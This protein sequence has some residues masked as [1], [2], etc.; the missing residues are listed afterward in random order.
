MLQQGYPGRMPRRC[1]RYAR[2][3]VK[4][5]VPRFGNY[6]GKHLDLAGGIAL[7]AF[8]S[9]SA[10]AKWEMIPSNSTCLSLELLKKCPDVFMGYA[11]P[12]IPVSTFTWILA[13]R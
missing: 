1:W 6:P 11:E 5:L 4:S 12:S 10:E 3:G 2:N 9:S 7:S 13:F 8:I